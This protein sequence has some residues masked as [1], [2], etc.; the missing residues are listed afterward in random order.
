MSRSLKE[1]NSAESCRTARVVWRRM[2]FRLTTSGGSGQLFTTRSSSLSSSDLP[3]PG[4]PLRYRLPDICCTDSSSSQ[5][6]TTRLS[7]ASR[8]S[9]LEAG[10]RESGSASVGAGAEV[11]S[12]ERTSSSDAESENDHTAG[13]CIAQGE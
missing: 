6:P 3:V 5:K 13:A 1:A 10:C 2:Q 11:A 9:S 8:Q 7:S 12:A 4:R